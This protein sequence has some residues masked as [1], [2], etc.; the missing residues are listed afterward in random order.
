MGPHRFVRSLALAA[1]VVAFVGMP[2]CGGGNN[3]TGTSPPGWAATGASLSGVMNVTD[4][5]IPAGTTRTATADLTINAGGKIQIDG[6]LLV[7][8]G[9]GVALLAKGP[10]TIN[11]AIQSTDAAS[12]RSRGATSLARNAAPLTRSGQ[13]PPRT[14]DDKPKPMVLHGQNVLI[15]VNA[16]VAP[17]AGQD[18]LIATDDA[19][20]TVTIERDI[21]LPHGYDA[22]NSTENGRDG[23]SIEVGTDR[24]VQAAKAAGAPTAGQPAKV[25][26]DTI[27]IKAGTGGAGWAEWNGKLVGGALQF[28]AS[29]GGNGGSVRI[30]AAQSVKKPVGQVTIIGGNGGAGGSAG[31]SEPTTP[32]DQ[33]PP[34]IATHAPD[35]KMVGEKGA[36][37]DF[38]SGDGGNG[39]DGEVVAPTIDTALNITAG[40]GGR[41]GSVLVSAGNGGPGGDGGKLTG[42]VGISGRDG[43]GQGMTPEGAHPAAT[44]YLTNGGNG[45]DAPDKD[46]PGGKGGAISFIGSDHNPAVIGA[47]QQDTQKSLRPGGFILRNYGNGGQGFNGCMNGGVNGTDGGSAG[48]NANG[49]ALQVHGVKPDEITASFVPGNGGDG[50]PP[51][52]AGQQSK[53]D[54][55]NLLGKA[56][57]NGSLCAIAGCGVPGGRSL[58]LRRRSP[59]GYTIVLLKDP[60]DLADGFFAGAAINDYGQVAGVTQGGLVDYQLFTP[61][62]MDGTSGTYT[63]FRGQGPHGGEIQAISSAGHVT[64]GYG[65]PANGGN[66]PTGYLWSPTTPNATTGTL[67]LLNDFVPRGVNA[68]GVSVGQNKE[69]KAAVRM[70]D[71]TIQVLPGVSSADLGSPSTATA[72]NDNGE[73]TAGPYLYSGGIPHPLKSLNGASGGGNAINAHGDVAGGVVGTP[74]AVFW[75]RGGDPVDLGKLLPQATYS[76]AFGINSQQDVVGYSLKNASVPSDQNTRAF[77]YSGGRMYDLNALIA[78]GSGWVLQHALSINDCGEIVCQGTLNGRSAVCLLIPK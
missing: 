65:W 71:G 58:A 11:G 19:T 66:G 72:I 46:H 16:K 64:A 73:V 52:K 6:T 15:D 62:S 42:S 63:S 50:A 74:R 61:S 22:G 41:G 17:W 33:T 53:D 34:T 70:K 23:G 7:T 8:P 9:V 60:D 30:H 13:T 43:M 54:T 26:L 78:S 12:S 32:N 28:F 67:T 25:V 5:S 55:G 36:D 27:F 18:V 39:G 10:L 3:A 68:S 31:R 44:V 51:G 38:F 20:G 48:L 59:S 69:F 40:Q 4:F 29:N 49:F 2:G 1:I 77:L 75:P 37:V 45:G 35:G 24:A 47:Y 14:R 76:G 57:N 56:A 21:I